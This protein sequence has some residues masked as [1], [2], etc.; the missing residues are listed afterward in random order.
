M[1]EPTKINISWTPPSLCAI[2]KLT[3]QAIQ[4]L[5]LVR[6]LSLGPP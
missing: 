1:E 5:S 3:S 4:I 2:Q 6:R